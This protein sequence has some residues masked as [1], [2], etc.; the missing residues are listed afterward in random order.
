LAA[1]GESCGSG[2]SDSPENEWR[3]FPMSLAAGVRRFFPP[4]VAAHLVKLACDLPDDQQRS[5]SL[6]TCAELARTLQRDGIVERISPQ[7]VRRIL[8]SYRLKPWR[9][10]YWLNA[11]GP[12]DEEFRR[13]T[14]EICDLYTREL[15]PYE[16]VL[17]VD[18]KTSLQPRTRKFATR[19]A[20]PDTPVRVE[21]EYK[22]SGALQLFGALDIRTGNV[23]GLCRARKC[24]EDFIELLAEIER[25]TPPSITR[26][27]IVCDNLGMHSGKKVLAWLESHPRFRFHFTPVHCSWMNQIEQW[28]SILQRKRLSAPNFQDL[29]DLESKL[30]SFIAEWNEHAHPFRWSK[31]SFAKVLAAAEDSLPCAA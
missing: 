6:W 30:R 21:H 25:Q 13:R 18:E 12:R 24:Q 7:S 4:A 11:K 15:E 31:A 17:C 5:L 22:R 2:R 27:H 28:F 10:H 3:A 29:G 1:V 9:S 14:E 20:R 23:I 16:R 8:G 19:A 26:I